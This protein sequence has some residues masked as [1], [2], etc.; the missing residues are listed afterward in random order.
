[1]TYFIAPP[2]TNIG[3]PGWQPL[4]PGLVLR[5]DILGSIPPLAVHRDGVLMS[6]GLPPQITNWPGWEFYD[7]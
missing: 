2:G 3:E 4:L 1:V 7:D 6:T 5:W